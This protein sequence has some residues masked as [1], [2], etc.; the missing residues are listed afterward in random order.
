MR[1][2]GLFVSSIAVLG[3]C[4]V[5]FAGPET[6]TFQSLAAGGAGTVFQGPTYVEGSFQ[7][8]NTSGSSSNA[9]GSHGIGSSSYAGSTGLF[10]N[11]VNG[12][13]ELTKVGGGSFTLSSI[14]FAQVFASAGG[15]SPVN[16][17]GTFS[18]GGTI[19]LPTISIVALTTPV[20]MTYNF[21]SAWTGLS[22][23]TW[24][25]GFRYNQFDNIVVEPENLIP[26]PGGAAMAMVGM[27]V[28][29]IRRRRG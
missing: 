25:Q 14:D 24:K 8:K 22:K 4:G 10:N 12:I 11:F 28:I 5:V 7:V 23:V 16:V 18:A 19:A 21:G 17:V 20:F 6:M 1:K 2:P 26:L 13:T 29:G 3:A 15:T 9:F 27:G